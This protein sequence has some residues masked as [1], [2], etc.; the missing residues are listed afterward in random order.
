M[1]INLANLIY[2][3]LFL[4][5]LVFGL[6]IRFD[7]V[8]FWKA[9]EH[10]F[11]Y[12]GEPLYS[13]FDSF[14]FA[15]LVK[16][17]EEGL[18]RPGKIDPFRFF[19]DNSSQAKID[20]EEFAPKYGI[21]STFI[22]NIFYFLSQL[23]GLS[24]AWLTWYLIPF[25]AISPAIPL[26]FYLKRLNLPF[27]GLAGGIVML[28]A[29]MYL[30]RTNLMRLDHDVLNLTFPILIA[31][32]FYLFFVSQTQR[33]KLIFVSLASLTLIFYQLWY[34][35]P[36]LCFVLVLIFIIYYFWEKRFKLSS[37]KKE[38]YLYLGLLIL[39]QL[40][41]LYTGPYHLYLQVKT[42][43]FGL[44]EQTSVEKLFSDFPNIF[45]SISELQRLS[46]EE[47]FATATYSTAFGVAGLI[48]AFL[49]FIFHF[50]SLF[51]LLPFFG[52]GLLTF[53][54][55]ARF[56]MY[57]SPFV[58]L[59]LGYLVHLLFEKLLPMMGLFVEERKRSFALLLTGTIL[60]LALI[61]ASR[62]A[63]S[64]VSTPKVHSFLVKDMDWIKHNTP[65]NSVIWTWWDYGYAFQLYAR[66]AT[67]HDGG[68]QASPKTYL[69][70]KSFAVSNPEQGWRFIS[71]TANYGLTGLAK[72]LKEGKRASAIVEDILAGKFDMP[73]KTPIY[74]VFTDDLISKFG[75]V[76]YFG[77]YDFN[78]KEGTFGQIVSPQDCRIIAPNVIQCADLDNAI[79]DLTN[80]IINIKNGTI[81]IKDFYFHDGKEL[82]AKHFFEN[83]YV[84][85]LVRTQGG[86]FGLFLLPPQQAD[87]LFNRMFILR[88]YD[89]RYF[90][91]VYDNFPTTVIY[92]VKPE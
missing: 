47:V 73:I 92:R 54:S 57:F 1:R 64:A 2:Y 70:A 42:L 80:G 83:G 62:G 53:V 76:H 79:L 29:P 9:N 43:V 55:G 38:D 41:Y 82:K 7:D 16:D 37:F 15:R 44:K 32:L 23:T 10:L 61:F 50:R 36:N 26:F 69:V 85:E 13:E 45:Q 91:L 87:T 51:F 17:M 89:P 35:H 33:K 90:E 21:S 74:V 68:S 40:W 71:F 86:K 48:G 66:R 52:I 14:F 81:P 67:I 34:G 18:Y 49:L 75:W 30:G 3:L 11:F 59:G 39:P 60:F 46:F 12:K 28:S 88:Q 27:A 65:K 72:L 78:K 56:A 84:V 4:V 19:P 22:S 8:Q 77:S 63:V 58:G 20:K 6:Y 25:L 5:V 31:F 24:V